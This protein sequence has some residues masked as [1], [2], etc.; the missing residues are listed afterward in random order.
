M[1][2]N[3]THFAYFYSFLPGQESGNVDV[4]LESGFGD[5]CE[6]PPQIGTQVGY[7]LQDADLMQTM[8]RAATQVG[9]P[10]AADDIV[11][12]IGSQTVACMNLNEK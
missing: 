9:N 11:R 4:V 3:L 6:D 5:Y 8:S 10:Y 7:W 2:A 12:S 1:V